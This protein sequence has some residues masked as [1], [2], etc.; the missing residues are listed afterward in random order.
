MSIFKSLVLLTII[1]IF[2]IISLAVRISIKKGVK[3]LVGLIFIY[4]MIVF[5]MSTKLSK[6][7]FELNPTIEQ[8]DTI[9]Q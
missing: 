9:K 5:F 1:G 3:A 6:I 8:T 2:S 4:A 7:P